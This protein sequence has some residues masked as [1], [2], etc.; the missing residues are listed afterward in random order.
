MPLYTVTESNT[1][2][3]SYQEALWE[4]SSFH[5]HLHFEQQ[6]ENE[7]QM[8]NRWKKDGNNFTL[9]QKECLQEPHKYKC[10]LSYKLYWDTG[11]DIE[12]SMESGFETRN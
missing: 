4:F 5:H 3:C 7:K 10:F 1:V 11:T 2:K 6:M 9:G 12:L 8:E